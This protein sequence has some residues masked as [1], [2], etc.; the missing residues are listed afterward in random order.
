MPQLRFALLALAGLVPMA[1]AASR[2]PENA[3]IDAKVRSVMAQTHAQGLAIAVIDN[4]RPVYVQAYGLRNGKGD[5]LTVDTVMYGASLTKPVFAY[6]V[7]R[8]AAQGR[9]DLDTSID[10]YL[11]K[12]LPEYGGEQIVDRYADWS[13][14]DA[15][16][17]KLTP[18]ILLTHSAG[19]ANFG[20]LEPDGKLR[21]HFDPGAHY[22]YSG[23]GLITLQFVMETGLR[24]DVGAETQ[25]IFKDYGMG[26]TSLIWRPDFSANLADG[27]DASGGTVAH[28]ER[29]KVRAAGS[30]DTTIADFAK[31]A[32]AFVRGDGLSRKRHADMLRPMLPITT[33]SQFPSLQP[34]L[35]VA[36]RRKDLAAGL[37]VVVFDGPQGRGFFK[38]G[39]DDITANTWVCVL[40][41]RR[42][43][44]ILSNDVRAEGG[45]RA[46]AEFVLGP[47]GVPYDWEYGPAPVAVSAPD[48]I[49]PIPGSS[50]MPA[51]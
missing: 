16:W 34:E 11:P 35:P 41:T 48:A 37:G 46:L 49:A 40:A 1:C 36:Q 17:R 44:V 23:D 9:I 27:W 50:P 30:M 42:C 29:S 12:P 28:D 3:A 5:P 31:F 20:F 14:L 33:R 22:A 6:T 25:R 21:F 39:H 15:R 38:G 19:F 13:A 47:T 26:R 7:M 45:F 10:K 4:G 32:A 8:L 43:L 24:I 2:L 18:R 51:L